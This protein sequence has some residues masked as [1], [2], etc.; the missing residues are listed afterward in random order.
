MFLTSIKAYLLLIR[1]VSSLREP[2]GDAYLK[3]EMFDKIL[4]LLA[5]QQIRILMMSESQSC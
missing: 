2:R 4:S 3:N 1:R 5:C